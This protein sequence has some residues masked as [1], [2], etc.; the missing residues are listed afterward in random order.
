MAIPDVLPGLKTKP[1]RHQ[2]AAFSFAR[3]KRGAMLAMGMGTGKS[4]VTVALLHDKRYSLILCPKAVMSVW[5]REFER[6]AGYLADV[7]VLSG[8]STKAKAGALKLSMD[9]AMVSG[10]QLV[11]VCNYDAAWREALADAML[12]VPWVPW[13]STRATRSR[14]RRGACPASAGN[15]ARW[16]SRCSD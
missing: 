6:H 13:C 11:V 12:A 3:S 1:W 9:R 2:R 4:L 8:R 5:P 16:R 10:R 14:P 7:V 15:C